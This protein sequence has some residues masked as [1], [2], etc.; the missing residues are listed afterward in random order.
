MV[1][2]NFKLHLVCSE[3]DVHVRSRLF[4]FVGQFSIF[5]TLD[6]SRVTVD[7]DAA[8]KSC[9]VFQHIRSAD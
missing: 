7:F 1:S 3:C 4:N 9:V 6:S 8:V 2:C 5:S